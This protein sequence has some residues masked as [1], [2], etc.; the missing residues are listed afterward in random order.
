ME[1]NI[2][3]SAPNWMNS[4]A[5]LTGEQ[6]KKHIRPLSE[7]ITW[8]GAYILDRMKDTAEVALLDYDQFNYLNRYKV[9]R[10]DV[11]KAFKDYILDTRRRTEV[12][13]DELI[14]IRTS[15][16]IHDLMW[17]VANV[18]PAIVSVHIADPSLGNVLEDQSDNGYQRTETYNLN[19]QKKSIVD[20]FEEPV[21][22]SSSWIPFA[23]A[24]PPQVHNNAPEP[25]LGKEMTDF[26]NNPKEM[27]K[28]SAEK[29]LT[30]HPWVGPT[31]QPSTLGPKAM[32]YFQ[33]MY[34]DYYNVAKLF[35]VEEL[36]ATMKSRLYLHLIDD[37]SDSS[38]EFNAPLE[39]NLR[40]LISTNDKVLSYVS[41]KPEVLKKALA[42][43]QDKQ[44]ELKKMLVLFDKTEQMFR[45]SNIKFDFE[46]S[47]VK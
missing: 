27:D 39:D 22:P 25:N 34:H 4:V 32:Q 12:Y 46:L 10:D 3:N 42:K 36:V 23:S 24:A 15:I 28:N 45:E 41:D 19:P 30:P 18:F 7:W 33:Q 37:Q 8:R 2:K 1:D 6:V 21:Q 31:F 35:T 9:F 38:Y 13:Q 17:R 40:E 44:V 5:Q 20:S 11:K 47:L 14:Q 26:I 16:F 29:Y 43:L